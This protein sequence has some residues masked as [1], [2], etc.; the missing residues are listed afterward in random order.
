MLLL[1]NFLNPSA[2]ISVSG[3]L[4]ELLKVAYICNLSRT[5]PPYLSPQFQHL[6]QVFHPSQQAIVV[7]NFYS[8]IMQS[9]HMAET[10][11]PAGRELH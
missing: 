7:S 8:L 5:N 2:A 3:E 4:L 11:A 9:H 1:L 10:I 6:Y